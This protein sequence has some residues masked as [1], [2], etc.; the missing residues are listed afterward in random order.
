MTAQLVQAI[1]A[2]GNNAN[3]SSSPGN[4][5]KFTLPE[6]V[7]TGNCLVLLQT[8]T[9]SVTVSAISDNING[10][11]STTAAQ[12]C[13]GANN[14]TNFYLKAGVSAGVTTVTVVFSGTVQGQPFTL[15]EWSG[16]ATSSPADG[17]ASNPSQNYNGTTPISTG[18]FTPAT[19]ND[20][21]G[22]HLILA[23]FYLDPFAATSHPTDFIASSGFTLLHADIGWEANGG[24]PKAASYQ[25]QT[26]NGS[27]NPAM[28]PTGD[29]NAADTY[30][31][32][33]LALKLSP[34]AGTPPSSS[35]RIVSQT[36]F[37]ETTGGAAFGW[38]NKCP[39]IGN[40]AVL[41]TFH[42]QFTAVSDS[43][44]NTWHYVPNDN[45]TP[46]LD[47]SSQIWY[48]NVTP[49]SN[50]F[51]TTTLNSGH[52]VPQVRFYDIAN[53]AS[54]NVL[55]AHGFTT[56]HAAGATQ[57]HSPDITPTT[58]GSRVIVVAE[59]GVGPVLAITNPA[60]AVLDM[61]PFTGASD[62]STYDSG[63]GWGHFPV[64]QA[65]VG[66]V[67]NVTWTINGTTFSVTTNAAEFLPGV[68]VPPAPPSQV[69]GII[70]LGS[71]EW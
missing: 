52:N 71:S 3:I 23:G 34:G 60:N 50:L 28:T 70:G 41:T 40:L 24:L 42:G 37:Y 33:A 20:A 6:P 11:W 39:I 7:G 21:N 22:G 44:G 19:N 26:T 62:S 55:G 29:T 25:V 38:K 10:S 65:M 64:T 54:S 5:Y 49:N 13:A 66:N 17:G 43:D 58:A 8:F 67:Q 53:A 48:A 61:V 47:N 15:M 4:T 9:N 56:T 2:Q 57:D 12:A 32:V 16:I 18:A 36:F 46:G 31:C 1:Y 45:P 63:N 35:M 27:V 30:N 69:F 68:V 51:I 59:D 14:N